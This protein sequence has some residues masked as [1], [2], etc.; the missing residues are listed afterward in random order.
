MAITSEIFR[1]LVAGI[2]KSPESA[3]VYGNQLTSNQSK[4]QEEKAIYNISSS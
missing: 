3:I 4:F 2:S 1:L